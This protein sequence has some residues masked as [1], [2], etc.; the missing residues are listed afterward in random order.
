MWG[1]P[2]F[3][4]DFNQREFSP[5]TFEKSQIRKL[6]W[7]PSCS[8][9]MDGRFG[10]TKQTVSFRNFTNAPKK[11]QTQTRMNNKKLPS[12]VRKSES[13]R[14][15]WINVTLLNVVH[16]CSH[17]CLQEVLISPWPDLLPDVFRLVVRIFRFLLVLFYTYIHT[18]IYIYIYSTRGLG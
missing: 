9:R 18:Y 17:H 1:T 2:L 4:S 12:R 3:V 16:T 10:M 5:Q 13:P 7:E 14:F 6:K 15:I 11:K 8:I